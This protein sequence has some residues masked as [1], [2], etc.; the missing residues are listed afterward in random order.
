KI[1]NEENLLR[2]RIDILMI[3]SS[4]QE[5]LKDYDGAILSIR[6]STALK[7]SLINEE[8]SRQVSELQTKYETEKKEQQI[9]LQQSELKGKNYII[10]GI[11]G[12]LLLGALL[13]LSYY[14]RYR[15]TQQ[16]RLQEAVMREQ[17]LAT[18]AVL[19]AE[20][21]ERKRIA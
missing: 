15:L 5:Q 8:T 7:D 11:S 13:A 21:N 4:I 10:G 9:A 3:K 17:E 18:H 19:E 6:A 16:A 1:T 2:E 20:E 14:R 12:V